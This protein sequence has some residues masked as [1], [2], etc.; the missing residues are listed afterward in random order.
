M[1]Q[2]IYSIR[3]EKEDNLA[4]DLLYLFRECE[5]Y[6][7]ISKIIDGEDRY[8]AYYSFDMVSSKGTNIRTQTYLLP[9]KDKAK[10]EELEKK[11]SLLLSGDNNVDVCTLL[12]IL[13]KKIKK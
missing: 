9:E 12:S 5:K 6:V 3:D 13:N 11:I 7:D 8:E 2:R 4:D 1:E 10:A